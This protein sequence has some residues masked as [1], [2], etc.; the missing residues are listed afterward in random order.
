[1]KIS[2]KMKHYTVKGYARSMFPTKAA[3]QYAARDNEELIVPVYEEVNLN[4]QGF[5]KSETIKDEDNGED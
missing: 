1:M 2:K 3:A 5:I 4:N